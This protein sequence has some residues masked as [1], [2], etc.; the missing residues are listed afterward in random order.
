[1]NSSA[2]HLHHTSCS[3]IAPQL[4]ARPRFLN[5]PHFPSPSLPLH[6]FFCTDTGIFLPSSMFKMSKRVF[7]DAPS[8]PK[9][10]SVSLPND[11][12]PRVGAVKRAATFERKPMKTSI[13]GGIIPDRSMTPLPG[14]HKTQRESKTGGQYS[15]T[16]TVSLASGIAD[17]RLFSSSSFFR[18]LFEE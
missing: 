13:F 18:A 15:R 10:G 17:G 3:T 7:G 5:V 6:F 12:D 2:N 16:R 11:N 1:M 14:S 8:T 9:L 4:V